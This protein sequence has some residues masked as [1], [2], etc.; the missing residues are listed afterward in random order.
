MK[1]KSFRRIWI[2]VMVSKFTFG[3]KEPQKSP[4]VVLKYLSYKK[5]FLRKI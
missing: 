1:A 4:R 5:V 3:E 2:S